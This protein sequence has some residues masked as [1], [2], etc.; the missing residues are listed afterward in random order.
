MDISNSKKQLG[1]L[2]DLM[3]LNS[4]DPPVQKLAT[5]IISAL[6]HGVTPDKGILKFSVGRE[7]ILNLIKQ[8]LR[9]VENGNSKLR[10]L[11]GCYGSGKTHILYILREFACKNNFASSVITLTPRECPLYDLGIMY[12][13]IIKGLRTE[14]CRYMPALE[15]IIK[16][17]FDKILAMGADDFQTVLKKIKRLSTDFQNVLTHYI[18]SSKKDSWQRADLSI[19]WIQGDLRNRR[20][21][22][23]VGANS[24]ACDQTALRMLQNIVLMLKVIG[25]SG[26][27]I[28]LDEAETIPSISSSSQIQ[29]AYDNLGRLINCNLETSNSYFVYATTP[30]FFKETEKYSLLNIPEKSII[31]L[32]P[33]PK[34]A[35]QKLAIHIRDLHIQ[36][37]KWNNINRLFREKVLKYVNQ[38]LESNEEGTLARNFVKAM[39]ASLDVC[40]ENSNLILCQTLRPAY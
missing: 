38:F 35:L 6:R 31:S 21:A 17:W 37:Y 3:K 29:H 7:E 33:L 30:E 24:Y 23:I 15:T 26:L 20:D 22:K 36:S 12:R 34:S 14:S 39:V 16:N 10:F 2:L 32:Q 19:R 11:N 4:A 28:L 40:Q 18:E 9:H 8:D 13:H 25:F 1:E 5:E 27:V